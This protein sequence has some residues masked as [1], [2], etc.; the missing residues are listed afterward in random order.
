[1]R[2]AVMGSGAVGGYFGARLALAGADVTFIARG[3]QLDAI[4]E[5]GIRLQSGAGDAHLP[6]AKATNDPAEVGP[7]DVVM[8]SV[9]LWDTEIAAHAIQPMIGPNTAVISFQNGV[10]KDELLRA[11]LGEGPVVGGVCYIAA[12][13][14]QPGVIVHKGALARLIFGEYGPTAGESVAAIGAP[15][16]NAPGRHAAVLGEFLAAARAAGIQAELSADIRRAI[17]EKFVFLVGLSA[18]T[19]ASRQNVGVVRSDPALRRTLL[20]VM[21]ETVAVA[22]REGVDLPADYDEQ[23]LAFFDGLPETM[24]SSMHHDLDRG[25]RLELDYLSGDVVARGERLGVPT[26]VNRTI[27]AVLRP[28]AEGRS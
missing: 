16:A 27:A 6:T 19:S 28:Y 7:V 18:T 25:N 5:N 20:E 24:T 26:P 8:F 21:K 11:V 9:K 4:R 2:I 22:R 15:A 1:M 17:W 3:A 12:A 23:R 13:L 14:E 10:R